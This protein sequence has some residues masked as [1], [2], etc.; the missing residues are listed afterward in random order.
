MIEFLRPPTRPPC[1]YREPHPVWCGQPDRVIYC[2]MTNLLKLLVC[3]LASLVRS[4][5][6][7]EAEILVLRHQLN[8]LRR[9]APMRP[10]LTSID[11]LIFVWFYRLFPS[12]ADALPSF[13]R[14]RSCDGTVLASGFTRWKSRSRGGRP[15]ITA[16]LRHLI[17]EISIANPLWGAPRIHGELLKLGFDVAQSTVAKYIAKG[18]RPPSQSWKTFLQNHAAGIAGMDFF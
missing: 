17:R 15:Q 3:F 2:V 12:I 1:A 7:L 8:V 9:A 4:R 14:I 11:R 16:E 10:R 5:A 6:R 13:S 18:R